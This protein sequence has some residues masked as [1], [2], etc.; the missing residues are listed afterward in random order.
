M[1]RTTAFVFVGNNEYEMT[2]FNPGGRTRLD[3]GKL[4]LYFTHHTGRFGLLWLALRALVGRLN[5]AGDFDAFGVTEATIETDEAR[6]LVATDGEVN[7]M[8]TP[9]SYRVRPAALRVLVPP[10]KETA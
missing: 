3:S 5:Q 1:A 6:L 4:G 10:P 7:W 2:G 9:L 8:E